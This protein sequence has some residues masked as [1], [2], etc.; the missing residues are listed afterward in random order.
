MRI[1][2]VRL[3]PLEIPF[4]FV[5]GVVITF[6]VD[7]PDLTDFRPTKDVDVVVEIMGYGSYA[8]LEERHRDGATMAGK[9]ICD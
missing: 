3:Q 4:V 9:M 7:H 1:V 5:G 6:L 8:R 2:A